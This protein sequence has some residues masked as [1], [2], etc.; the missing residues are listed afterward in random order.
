MRIKPL[1]MPKKVNIEKKDKKYGSFSISPLERGYGITIGH[2]LR[3]MLISS[4]QGA[5]ITAINIQGIMHEFSTI[6]NV[7]EDTAQIILNL[8]KIRLRYTAK[9]LP[10]YVILEK[11]GPGKV[12]ASDIRLTPNLEVANPDQ[13]IAT[14]ETGAELKATMRVDVGRGFIP[15]ES[16]SDLEMPE[17]TIYLDTNFSPVKRVI[18][19]VNNVRVGQRT[20]FEKLTMQIWTDGSIYPDEA[21][22][23]AAKV[24]RGH[25]ELFV[26]EGIFVEEEK[27]SLEDKK[28]KISKALEISV[29]ELDMGNR[30][31]NVLKKQ[32][33][34]KLKDIVTKKEEE[35]LSFLNFGEISLR[36]VKNKLKDYDLCLDMDISD[37]LGDKNETQ[38][39][40]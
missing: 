22:N 29:E 15:R 13:L 21:L 31:M 30:V 32:N 1:I 9:E 36:E 38:K 26:D 10:Q 24:L 40:K 27:E 4:I 11:K 17:G 33:I 12:K 5:A 28:E 39:E 25:L 7:K 16:F 18:Y 6:E 8:K 14:L 34:N 23:L 37:Y 3:R 20:D 35:L 2:A 19:E